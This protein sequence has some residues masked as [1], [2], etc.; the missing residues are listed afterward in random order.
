M[1]KVL[2]VSDSHGLV[3]ELSEIQSRHQVDY[4]IHCG[5]SELEFDSNPL[6]GFYKVRGNCDYDRRFPEEEIFELDG[7]NFL[8]VHGHLHQV[9]IGHDTLISRAKEVGADVVCY[10]H[11]HVA[12]ATTKSSHLIINPGSIVFPRGGI[13]EKTYAILEWENKED[14]QVKFF[15][16]DGKRYEDLDYQTSLI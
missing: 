15:T 8:V 2:I 3:K 14:V 16:L 5:D 7:M 11:T 12:E 1:T 10:G 6:N 9:K 4:R 13:R